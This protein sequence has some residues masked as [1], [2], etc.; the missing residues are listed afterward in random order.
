MGETVDRK[1]PTSGQ[2]HK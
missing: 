2:M 1:I